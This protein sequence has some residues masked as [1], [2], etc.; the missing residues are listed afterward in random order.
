MNNC[1]RVVCSHAGSCDAL[2]AGLRNSSACVHFMTHHFNMSRLG[3]CCQPLMEF[4]DNI[5]KVLGKFHCFSI[6]IRHGSVT[7]ERSTHDMLSRRDRFHTVCEYFCKKQSG[8][9]VAWRVVVQD[10]CR[11]T[12]NPLNRWQHSGY[13]TQN[14]NVFFNFSTGES[15]KDLYRS[16]FTSTNITYMYC[17]KN[18]K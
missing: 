3:N 16:H 14:A 15:H 4:S 10:A 18:P 17:I 1:L 5:K 11:N 13:I 6:N 2:Y 8:S 7:E 12:R 9:S